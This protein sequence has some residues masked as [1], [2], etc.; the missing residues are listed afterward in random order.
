MCKLTNEYAKI[1]VFIV[2]LNDTL[3]VTL[4]KCMMTYKCK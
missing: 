1:R 3:N 4:R 2:T